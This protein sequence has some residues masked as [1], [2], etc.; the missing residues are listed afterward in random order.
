MNIFEFASRNKLRFQTAQ[1]YIS[2]EELWELPL[3]SK[4]GRANLDAVAINLHAKLQTTQL[5]FVQKETVNNQADQV[6]FDIVKYII[7][8]RLAEAAAKA[9]AESRKERKHQ[10]LTLLAE[11][12]TEEL[13]GKTSEEIQALIAAL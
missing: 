5:S 13:R 3:S 1:G 11:K 8:V 10:L 9:D 6:A 4:T 7:E 12:Q 2:V